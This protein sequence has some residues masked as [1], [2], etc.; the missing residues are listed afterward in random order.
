MTVVDEKESQRKLNQKSINQG[1]LMLYIVWNKV[2]TIAI[3]AV[4]RY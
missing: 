4:N 1:R 2:L 3:L